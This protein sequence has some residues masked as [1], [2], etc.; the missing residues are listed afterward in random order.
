M[1]SGSG[2]NSESGDSNGDDLGINQDQGA[3]LEE[4][5]VQSSVEL[6]ENSEDLGETLVEGGQ[7]GQV[8]EAVRQDAEESDGDGIEQKGKPEAK[9]TRAPVL[10]YSDMDETERVENLRQVAKNVKETNVK[11]VCM[12]KAK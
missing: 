5:E 1:S 9:R 12:G 3:Q 6:V 11:L 8:L 10:R 7:V 2:G 4:S